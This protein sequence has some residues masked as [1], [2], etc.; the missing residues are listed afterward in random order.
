MDN[1]IRIEFRGIAGLLP[2]GS[3][4][5]VEHCEAGVL[6]VRLVKPGDPLPA[7][8]E[9]TPEPGTPVG[10]SLTNGNEDHNA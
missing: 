5:T 7:T 4:V 2:V 6:I 10:P 9:P 3:V 8:V 1:L